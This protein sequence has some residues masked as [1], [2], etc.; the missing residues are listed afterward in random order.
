MNVERNTACPQCG[1]RNLGIQ[2]RCLFC[3]ETLPTPG[4]AHAVQ[5]R[6]EPNGE[7]RHCS[8]CGETA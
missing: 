8:N 1:A 7:E 3:G 5:V 4:A 2:E 6:G